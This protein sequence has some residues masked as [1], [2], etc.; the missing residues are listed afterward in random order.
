MLNSEVVEQRD[1]T[2]APSK[3]DLNFRTLHMLEK[4]PQQRIA[5]GGRQPFDARG[6]L[7]VYVQHPAT[8]AWMGCDDRMADGQASRQVLRNL[9]QARTTRAFYQRTRGM[10]RPQAVQHLSYRRREQIVGCVHSG[11]AGVATAIR[12]AVG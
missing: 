8:G 9:I 7:R 5:F 10:D 6:P 11:K 3:A 2:L 12:Q 1:I 4:K